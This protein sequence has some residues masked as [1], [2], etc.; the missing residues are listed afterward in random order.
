M[1]VLLAKVAAAV[2]GL[3]PGIGLVVS[4]VVAAMVV[5]PVR[6]RGFSRVGGGKSRGFRLFGG[7]H[8]Y[9]KQQLWIVSDLFAGYPLPCRVSCGDNS[10]SNWLLGGGLHVA[11]V[12]GT[13]CACRSG[14]GGCGGCGCG[15]CSCCAEGDGV[16]F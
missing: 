2:E 8:S 11:V 9:A 4:L 1:A 6:R 12:A 10:E 13:R 16:V 5:M 14:Y 3:Q 7:F 15:G